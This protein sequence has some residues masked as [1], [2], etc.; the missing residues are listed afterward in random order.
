MRVVVTGASGNVGTSLVRLLNDEESVDH[1]IGIARRLPE[2]GT[3][4]AEWR[5]IDVSRDDLSDTFRGADAVVHLAWVDQPAR[6]PSYLRDVNVGGSARVF[7]AAAAARVR[8]L[9]YA[10]SSGAYSRA[11]SG[12]VLGESWPT[13][14]VPTSTHS[15]H[16][17]EVEH[18]LDRFQRE[19]Q[20]VRVV[21]V[22]SSLA[23]KAEAA[24]GFRRKYFGGLATVAG[25]CVSRMSVFPEVPGVAI[26]VVHTDDLAEAYRLALFGSVTGAYNVAATPSLD[27]AAI[28]DQL[29][30]R[31]IRVGADLARKAVALGWTLRLTSFEPGWVDLAI[32]SA[33]V[34]TARATDELGW[35]PAHTG[36]QVLR[37]TAEGLRTGAGFPTP[38][39]HPVHR[40][41]R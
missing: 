24:S 30:F 33:S 7:E 2:E 28:A 9:L 37:E 38:P 6:K 4:G 32:S 26:D 8:T 36:Y 3:L 34:D 11:P 27:G 29:G 15:R 18:L 13:D 41:G 20:F 5:Q 39:L 10:S 17:A 23:L 25:A 35:K 16:K 12:T 21:R 22:R 31:R 40:P 14:G 1:I 19:H